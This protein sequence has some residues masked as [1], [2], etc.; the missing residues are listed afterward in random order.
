MKQWWR[1]VEWSLA[2]WLERAWQLEH[3]LRCGRKHQE[4]CAHHI[5]RFPG[6]EVSVELDRQVLESLRLLIKRGRQLG[7]PGQGYRGDHWTT[8]ALMDCNNQLARLERIRDRN[9]N[10]PDQELTP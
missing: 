7:R 10:L 9:S 1:Q 5:A 3:S 6:G 2:E 8:P 4:T